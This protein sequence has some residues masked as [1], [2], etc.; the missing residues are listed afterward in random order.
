MNNPKC[1]IRGIKAIANRH[2]TVVRKPD[3]EHSGC[4]CKKM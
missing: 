3:I 2:F 4:I 1:I